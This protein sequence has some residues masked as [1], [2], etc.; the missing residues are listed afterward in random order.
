[1]AG[2]S[3]PVS[4][5]ITAKDAASSVL[6]GLTGDIRGMSDATDEATQVTAR[7]AAAHEGLEEAQGK[8]ADITQI[9]TDAEAQAAENRRLNVEET[10]AYMGALRGLEEAE[11]EVKKAE[12]EVAAAQREHNAVMQ[13]NKQAAEDL[14]GAYAT[15]GRQAGILGAA[16]VGGIT[17]SAVAAGKY[18]QELLEFSE[19]T[20]IAVEKTSLLRYAAEQS[21][22]TF[23][24]LE[25]AV[26]GLA[27]TSLDSAEKRI[28][29]AQMAAEAEQKAARGTA[30]ARA[31]AAAATERSGASAAEATIKSTRRIADARRAQTDAARRTARAVVDAE[32]SIERAGRRGMSVAEA[33]E[34]AARRI[35]DARR[36]EA[37]AAERTARAIADGHRQTARA[38]DTAADR[39]VAASRRVVKA[40]EAE[41]AARRQAARSMR[42]AEGAYGSLGIEIRNH[43]GTLKTSYELFLEVADAVAKETNALKQSAMAQKVFGESG[44]QLLPLLKEGRAGIEA[45]AAEAKRLNLIWD[46]ETA[47][48]AD[49]F[50]DSLSG[51]KRAVQS[52]GAALFVGKEGATGLLDSITGL[53]G[54]VGGFLREHPMFAKAVA[55]IGLVAGGA[56][57]G[58]SI[59]TRGVLTLST[60]IIALKLV[61]GT[62]AGPAG[63]AGLGISATRAGVA[64]AG[65]GTAITSTLIPAIVAIAPYA[66]VAAAAVVMIAL[67]W[68]D[69]IV[70]M[71]TYAE[72]RKRIM[73]EEEARGKYLTPEQRAEIEGVRPTVGERIRGVFTGGG[74]TGQTLAQH[75]AF[76]EQGYSPEE[77]RAMGKQVTVVNHFHGDIYREDD[78]EGKIARGV[79]N[80]MVGAR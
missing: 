33:R 31:A 67:A 68:R 24:Q 2:K 49:R 70:V 29:A 41:G 39:Q 78:I 10:K 42:E 59:L 66:A 26:A 36:A 40:Q 5:I 74:E 16:I 72:R 8:L 15:L 52:L 6:S 7:L 71:E 60:S 19:K 51:M 25:T 18:G 43:E 63:L 62:A 35:G 80:A 54:G 14:K 28:K 4:I 11:Q 58:V 9:L 53:I 38:A 76:V 1:M 13:Q 45:Y 73:Q 64:A 21:G 22:V 75:R 77:L 47:E 56:L 3:F 30:D 37:R 44:R 61:T 23:G 79:T 65:A 12:Q 32:R 34:K 46:R 48:A 55:G 27:R 57:I 17:A 50:M 69:A 20:G